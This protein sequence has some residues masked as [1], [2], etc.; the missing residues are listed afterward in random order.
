MGYMSRSQP[1]SCV[2]LDRVKGPMQE[3]MEYVHKVLATINVLEDVV[4]KYKKK[5]NAEK[6]REVGPLLSLDDVV[7]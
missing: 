5:E 6:T 2:L 3:T 7:L 1:Y 4:K